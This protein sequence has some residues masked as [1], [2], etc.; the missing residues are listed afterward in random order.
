M[1]VQRHAPTALT[2]GKTRYTL[3]RRLGRPHIPSGWVRKLMLPP[4]FDPWTIQPITIRCTDYGIPAQVNGKKL[5]KVN[6]IFMA[7]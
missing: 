2:S 4:G 1:A 3:Y 7:I 6:Y 5:T